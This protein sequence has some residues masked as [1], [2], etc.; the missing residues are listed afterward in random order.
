MISFI[1]RH[2]ILLAKIIIITGYGI[3]I[4]GLWIMRHNPQAFQLSWIFTTLSLVILLV[5]HN[6]YT[7]KF[8]LT[9][10]AVGIIGWVVEAI[11]TSTGII[12]GGYTYG[13]SL[14]PKL[15]DTP[16]V[17]LINWMISTYLVIMVLK[18][19]FINV[20]RLALVGASLMVLY[21][22]LLEPVAIRLFMWNWETGTPPLQN[23]IAW[24]IVSFPLVFLLSRQTKDTSNPLAIMLFTCQL[25]FFAILNVLIGFYNM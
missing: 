6:P 4:P 14:G 10:L 9:I 1:N 21:D 13:P 15:L 7:V 25:I 23:Y 3:S 22:I 17:M 16:I 11:G 19:I 5:F 24:F 2:K 12:F 18:P 20:W 8:T